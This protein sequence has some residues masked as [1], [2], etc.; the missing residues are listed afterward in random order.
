MAL[1]LA[2]LH[3][4]K[5]KE[6]EKKQKQYTTQY[7]VTMVTISTFCLKNIVLTMQ[8]FLLLMI[9]FQCLLKRIDEQPHGTSSRVTFIT[10]IYSQVNEVIH[11]E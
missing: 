7:P 8:S 6:K 9:T 2:V 5:K 11:N 4:I 1:N 3:A 10:L